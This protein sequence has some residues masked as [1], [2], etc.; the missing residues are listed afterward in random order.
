MGRSMAG[1]R[2]M[3]GILLA[4]AT[5][6]GAAA[7]PALRAD[8]Q[9]VAQ[10][11]VFFAHQ[12]VGANLLAGLQQ[13]ATSE[14]IALRIDDMLVPENGEPLRKLRSF[15]EALDKRAGTVDVAMLKFCYV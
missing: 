8:L 1:I 4:L 2:L 3:T 14:K 12:S 15:E 6:D 13:L 7:D 11:R 5:V 9:R 10:E